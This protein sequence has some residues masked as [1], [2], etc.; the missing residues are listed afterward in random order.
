[1]Y[2]TEYGLELDAAELCRMCASLS[3][4]GISLVRMWPALTTILQEQRPGFQAPTWVIMQSAIKLYLLLTCL[5]LGPR[6]IRSYLRTLR[7]KILEQDMNPQ[8]S[9]SV[10]CAVGVLW[11]LITDPDTL[12]LEDSGR[13]VAV[14]RILHAMKRLPS[15]LRD[16]VSLLIDQAVLG[17]PGVSSMSMES[18]SKLEVDIRTSF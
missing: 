15:D 1:M 12:M 17:A 6:Q 2:S 8:I 11:L 5:E 16:R 10:P 4:L 18:I 14:T 13:L 7:Q 9:L 3:G